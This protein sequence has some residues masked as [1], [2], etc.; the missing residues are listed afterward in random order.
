MGNKS[1]ISTFDKHMMRS[2]LRC[3]SQNEVNR[4]YASGL[5]AGMGTMYL[6]KGG[7]VAGLCEI[8]A[9]NLPRGYR[10]ELLPGYY[11]DGIREYQEKRE[12]EKNE[13]KKS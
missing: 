7:N 11:L 12:R 5:I 4:D 3:F 9:Q 8:L 13:R 2:M 10:E 6:C 1:R